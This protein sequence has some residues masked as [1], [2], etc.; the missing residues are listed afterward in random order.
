[1]KNISCFG[2]EGTPFFGTPGSVQL[3]PQAEQKSKS[4]NQTMKIKRYDI[5]V[6][7][8][9]TSPTNK[10]SVCIEGVFWCTG[11]KQLSLSIGF[12]TG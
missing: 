1:M 12:K 6:C 5:I 8:L 4:N 10:L 2:F 11:S 3:W 7:S 9:N